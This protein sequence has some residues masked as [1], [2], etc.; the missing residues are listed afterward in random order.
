MAIQKLDYFIIKEGKILNG[1]VPSVSLCIT[2]GGIPP[3][4]DFQRPFSH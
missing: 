1:N 2:Y 4:L 3:I